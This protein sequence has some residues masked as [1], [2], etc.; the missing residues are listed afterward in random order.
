MIPIKLFNRMAEKRHQG[1][2]TDT[3]SKYR[4]KLAVMNSKETS[5]ADE[6]GNQE[7]IVIS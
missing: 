4:S 3:K 7:Y 2:G 6:E 5:S 1:N